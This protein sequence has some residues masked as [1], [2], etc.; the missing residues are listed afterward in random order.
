MSV[1]YSSLDGA[2]VLISGGASGIGAEMVRQFAA[3]GAKVS[4]LDID[5]DAAEDLV[6][7]TGAR[8]LHCDLT[9]I[10]A[11][12]AAVTAADAAWPTKV[13]IN[14]AARDNRHAVGDVEPELWRRTLALNLDHQFFGAQAIAKPMAARGGGSIVLMGSV[15]WMR[16][17][18]GMV[19]YTTAKAAINGMTRTLAREWGEGGVRVNCIV[20]GAVL[21]ERQASLWRSPEIDAGIQTA[22]AL[23][24]VLSPPHVAAMAVFLGSDEA[25]G[26][27]GQNF[28]VDAG[29]SLN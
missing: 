14:N 13:M 11:L 25:A 9:D 1:R 21:T 18:P 17:R 27:T 6:A 5:D 3:Q 20:P 28:V 24:I 2:G 8:Y 7:E 23:K 29:I 16:A 4:F 12:R 26:C 15:S 19:G 22:Q 10:A